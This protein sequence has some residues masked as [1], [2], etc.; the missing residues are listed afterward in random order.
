M[1]SPAEVG[2][3][4]RVDRSRRSESRMVPASAARRP[5]HAGR[6][7]ANIAS[8]R[9]GAMLILEPLLDKLNFI[10]RFY[11]I[12]SEPFVTTIGKIER[13]EEPYHQFDVEEEEPPF[14]VE[15]LDA[16]ES[17]NILGKSCLCLVQNAFRNYLD[18]FVEHYTYGPSNEVVGKSPA[19]VKGNWFENYRKFFLRT[20]GID[21]AKSPIDIHFLEEI[22]FVRNDIQHGGMFYSLEHRQNPEYFKRFPE[23]IFTEEWVTG[24]PGRVVVSKN[25]LF[26]AIQAIEDFC[27]YLEG[28]WEKLAMWWVEPR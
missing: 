28:E 2:P 18:G 14:L 16:D 20:Y 27:S 24:P 5:G 10:R 9:K 7:A 13:H 25:N 3:N 26:I 12:A 19:N 21:W 17:L 4:N 15:W 11:D 23:S 1:Q 8:N 6:Y 22:N